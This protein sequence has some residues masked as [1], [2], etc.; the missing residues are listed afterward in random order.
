MKK[1]LF[2]AASAALALPALAQESKPA[3][4][5]DKHSITISLPK[6][7][8]PEDDEEGY[9]YEKDVYNPDEDEDAQ[10]SALTENDADDVD[11]LEEDA[12]E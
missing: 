9:L 10:A 1:L 7:D 5:E 8:L 2:I 3:A 12:E 11:S 4:A 6:V